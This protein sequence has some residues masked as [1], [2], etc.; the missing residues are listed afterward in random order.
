MQ[1]RMDEKEAELEEL[2]GRLGLAVALPDLLWRGVLHLLAV[3]ELLLCEA[4]VA[5]ADPASTIAL[6]V[7]SAT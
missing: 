4:L 1:A 3:H 5:T 7:H 2:R 6:I